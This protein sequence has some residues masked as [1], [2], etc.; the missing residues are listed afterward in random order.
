MTKTRNSKSPARA[1]KKSPRKKA[2]RKKPPSS[3]SGPPVH[4]GDALRAAG[5]DERNVAKRYANALE[6]LED[7]PENGAVKLSVD[8]LD[9]V[10]RWLEPPRP[11]SGAPGDAPM[12]V[13]LIH[14]ASRPSRL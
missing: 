9:K 14:F 6:K 13:N 12:T 1:Q 3:S 8:I 4:L 5:L 10:T 11:A 2:R 7:S